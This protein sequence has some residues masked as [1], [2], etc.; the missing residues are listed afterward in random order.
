MKGRAKLEANKRPS[1]E[2]GPDHPTFSS[3]LQRAGLQVRRL[4]FWNLLLINLMI[5]GLGVLIRRVRIIR[6]GQRLNGTGYMST[7]FI[8]AA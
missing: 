7:C 6:E 5:L 4:G 2:K 8:V 3:C 1:R